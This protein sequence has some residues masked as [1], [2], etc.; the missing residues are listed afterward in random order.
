[1]SLDLKP[2]FPRKRESKAIHGL[3]IP[4]RLDSGVRRNDDSAGSEGQR[5]HFGCER[6]SLTI[7]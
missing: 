1:M 5:V 3:M 7:F 6:V 4:K 2:S